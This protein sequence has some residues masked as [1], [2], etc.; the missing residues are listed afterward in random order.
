MAQHA[1][2]DTEVYARYAK[3]HPAEVQA[4]FREMLINVTSFFRDPQAFAALKQEVLPQL[5]GGKPEG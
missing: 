3:E 1:I 2:E 4:L 5:L